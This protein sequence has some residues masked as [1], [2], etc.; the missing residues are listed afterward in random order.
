MM[1]QTRSDRWTRAL[2]YAAIGATPGAPLGLAVALLVRLIAAPSADIADMATFGAIYAV[3]PL[4]GLILGSGV[5]AAASRAGLLAGTVGAIAAAGLYCYG[6]MY[7]G[8]VGCGII[9]VC[10]APYI[11][12]SYPAA[13]WSTAFTVFGAGS[14]VS[15]GVAWVARRVPWS[16][17]PIT[18]EAEP[19]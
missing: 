9:F 14:I 3:G 8:G 12:W 13:A 19:E 16:R 5:G 18:G 10:S 7:V 2:W 11:T 4:V 17:G 6:A 15:L 1:R